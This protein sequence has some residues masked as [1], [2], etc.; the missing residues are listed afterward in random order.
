M[1][2]VEWDAW[3]D[4]E[5]SIHEHVAWSKDKLVV[6]TKMLCKRKV[7]EDGTVD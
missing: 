7:E 2:S 5:N 6:D 4:T 3:H 1:K